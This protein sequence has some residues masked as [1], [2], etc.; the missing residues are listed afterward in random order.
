M[1]TCYGVTTGFARSIVRRKLKWVSRLPGFTSSDRDDIEQDIFHDIIQASEQFKPSMG[2]VNAFVA[3]VVERSTAGVIRSRNAQKRRV[4]RA[5][6]IGDGSEL[7]CKC[8]AARFN[9]VDLKCDLEP[10]MAQ[11]PTSLRDLANR[12]K[13][14]SV[15]QVARDLGRHITSVRR[16]MKQILRVFDKAGLQ[17][18][19]KNFV[20]D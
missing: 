12:L 3:T 11:L 13:I 5:M 20:S 15:S 17:V 14:D 4:D 19:L 2:H 6:P 18:Y 8:A 10:A 1:A 9:E 16:D 7:S